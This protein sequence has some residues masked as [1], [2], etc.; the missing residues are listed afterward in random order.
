MLDIRIRIK[1]RL[2]PDDLRVIAL[3]ANKVSKECE[4]YLENVFEGRHVELKEYHYRVNI[5]HNIITFY[6]ITKQGGN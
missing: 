6:D 2:T 5:G 1:K 4:N 3:V